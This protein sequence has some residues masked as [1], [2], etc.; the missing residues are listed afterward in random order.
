MTE[1]QA[2]GSA[3]V[4]TGQRTALHAAAAIGDTARLAAL[5]KQAGAA[6]AV[7]GPDTRGFT[8]FHVACAGG[9]ADCVVALCQAGADIELK[10]DVGLRGW[11]LAAQLHRAEVLGLDRAGLEQ[12]ARRARTK[13]TGRSKG[14]S[15]GKAAA[16]SGKAEAAAA[17]KPPSFARHASEPTGAAAAGGPKTVVL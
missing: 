3:A 11:E 5:L 6:G 1:A 9:H 13:A 4:A 15:Q 17:K 14:K 16:G 7:D 10:N 8:A 2:Y 12:V